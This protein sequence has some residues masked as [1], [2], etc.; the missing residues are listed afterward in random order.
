MKLAKVMA[1]GMIGLMPLNAAKAQSLKLVPE[2]GCFGTVKTAP[3]AI[4]GLNLVHATPKNYADVFAGGTINKDGVPG[5]AGIAFDNFS[6][7]KHFGSWARDLFMA[8]KDGVTSTL[9]VA[10]IKYN[11]SAGNFNFSVM[12][13][14]GRY[15]NYTDKTA[16]HGIK[17][18]VQAMY[19]MTPRDRLCLEMQYASTPTSNITDTYFGKPADCFN[20]TATYSH[21]INFKP[22]NKQ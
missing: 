4:G 9:D 20:F 21:D 3:T 15:D 7:S 17:G 12:P 10:P 11:V 13:A 14:Y 18:I 16:F 2:A 5:F 8:S 1:V 22:A 6:W 19:S